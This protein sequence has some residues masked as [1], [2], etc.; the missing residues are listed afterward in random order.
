MALIAVDADTVVYTK[1]DAPA[2]VVLF[3][4][5]KAMLTGEPPRETY[6]VREV[7]GE[8]MGRGEGR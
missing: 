3:E 8:E 6:K 2:P 1:K 4:M 5:A 7:T